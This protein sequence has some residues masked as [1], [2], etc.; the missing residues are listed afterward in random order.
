MQIEDKE[1]IGI[2]KKLSELKN[3][4]FLISKEN[5][6]DI[7][8]TRKQAFFLFCLTFSIFSFY[9]YISSFFLSRFDY[10]INTYENHKGTSELFLSCFGAASAW[11]SLFIYKSMDNHNYFQER[12]KSLSSLIETFLAAFF[13][14]LVLGA[15]SA[16]IYIATIGFFL[17]LLKNNF[18]IN[19][20]EINN[21][22]LASLSFF[23]I[24]FYFKKTKIVFVKNENEQKKIIHKK[25]EKL[26]PEIKKIE[27]EEAILRQ[28]I[29]DSI[30][31]I[32]E[33][34]YFKYLINNSTLN[35]VNRYYGVIEDK[36]LE[37]SPYQTFDEYEK[38][39]L[40][41]RLNKNKTLIINN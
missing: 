12:F 30:S 33:L 40:V 17:L 34:A 41:E 4:K 19:V 38:D 13:A 31:N 32:D 35:E 29:I 18:N 1:I 8:L 24:L 25:E 11:L 5:K 16:L 26:L 22:I 39:L 27:K 36:I 20:Q 14:C 7:P 10:N 28:K 21:V 37:N 2:N 3:Q 6:E 15:I 9:F 23:T